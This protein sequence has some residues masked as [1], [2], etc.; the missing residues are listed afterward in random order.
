VP[1]FPGSPYREVIVPPYRVLYRRHGDDLVVVGI[2]H[3]A[4]LPREPEQD[5]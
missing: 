2:R 3:E 1:E 4:R 5:A